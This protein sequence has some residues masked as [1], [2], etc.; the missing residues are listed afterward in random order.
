[1]EDRSDDPG[2]FIKL[3]IPDIF[4]GNRHIPG[5]ITGI[6]VRDQPIDQADQGRLS[7]AGRPAEK[8]GLPFSE[9]KRHVI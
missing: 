3:G 8:H 1:M 7:A 5:N 9:R 2:K 6:V 4:P